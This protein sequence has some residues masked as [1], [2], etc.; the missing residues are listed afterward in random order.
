[1]RLLPLTTDKLRSSSQLPIYLLSN[2]CHLLPGIPHQT[3]QL[4]TMVLKGH[5]LCKAVTYT[6]DVDAPLITGYD[7]CDDCQRQSGSTYCKFYTFTLSLCA[8]FRS[9]STWRGPARELESLGRRHRGAGN[10]GPHPRKLQRCGCREA[11]TR[12][13]VLRRELRPR[14]MGPLCGPSTVNGPLACGS[15]A[16]KLTLRCFIA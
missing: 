3:A 10:G 6:V 1:M 8:S 4:I 12:P 5:C 15:P 9:P 7:H 11:L 14:V 16:R 13:L 2:S